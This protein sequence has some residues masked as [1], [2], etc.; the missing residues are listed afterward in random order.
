LGESTLERQCVGALG[1]STVAVAT[2][3]MEEAGGPLQKVTAHQKAA[4]GDNADSNREG[5]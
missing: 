4:D 1:V 2:A 5:R 3:E